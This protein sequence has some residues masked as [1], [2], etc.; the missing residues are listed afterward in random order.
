VP[1]GQENDP[2]SRKDGTY[3]NASA[4]SNRIPDLRTIVS[5]SVSYDRLQ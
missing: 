5:N 2:E 1:G 4:E 3:P